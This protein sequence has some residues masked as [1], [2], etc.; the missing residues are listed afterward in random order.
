MAARLL[1][2]FVR[3]MINLRWEDARD[4]FYAP[5]AHPD[6]LAEKGAAFERDRWTWYCHLDA[7]NQS[8]A[9]K[10]VEEAMRDA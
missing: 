2:S 10:A 5:D 3:W 7:E 9:L 8:K 1:K 4:L 6:Y